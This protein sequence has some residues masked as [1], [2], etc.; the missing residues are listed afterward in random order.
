[1]PPELN[2]LPNGQ[3]RSR[4]AWLTPSSIRWRLQLI[5]QVPLLLAV[6]LLLPIGAYL[7]YVSLQNQWVLE[8]DRI[9]QLLVSDMAMVVYRDGAQEDIFQLKTKLVN[10]EDVDLLRIVNQAGERFEVLSESTVECSI[11]LEGTDS[12]EAHFHQ[13]YLHYFGPLILDG[14]LLGNVEILRATDSLVVSRNRH[15]MVLALLLIVEFILSWSSA[16]W[17][18]RIV[19]RPLVSPC[20]SLRCCSWPDCRLVRRSLRPS[21]SI[22]PW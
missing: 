15:L 8:T 7:D 2:E 19:S 11:S 9:H 18:Q 6:I 1:M 13:G 21:R 5:T 20:V 10:L 22:A 16:Y 12:A 14:V 3:P 17:A 4:F